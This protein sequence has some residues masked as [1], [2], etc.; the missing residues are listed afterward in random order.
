MI[1][2]PNKIFDITLPILILLCTALFTAELSGQDQ[3]KLS[4]QDPIEGPCGQS[5]KGKPRRIKGGEGFPPL[6]LPVTPL[7]R[8]ERKRNPAPPTLIGK[9]IWGQERELTRADGKTVRYFDWNNDPSDLKRLLERARK[10][11]GI[12]YGTK[13]LDPATFSFDPDEIPILWITGTQAVSFT[14]ELRANLRTYLQRGGSLWGDACRGSKRFSTAF[15]KEIALILP[16]GRLRPL[17]PDHPIFTSAINLEGKARYSPWTDDRPD[18]APYLEGINI[19]CRTAILFCPYA[20]TCAWDS[21]HIS[22]G[23]AQ[24]EEESA[25]AL[26]M[27]MLAYTLASRPLGRFLAQP[28]NAFAQDPEPGGFVFAQARF[29]GE[30]NPDPGAFGRLLRS[31]TTRTH[32]KVALNHPYL[33]L[34]RIHPRD[35]PFLYLTGHGSFSLSSDERKGLASF[36]AAGGFLLADACCGDLEFDR[37][38]RRLM[39]SL[40]PEGGLSEIP[41]NDPLFFSPATI[42]TVSYTPRVRVTWPELQRPMLEG[43]AIE[44]TWRVVYSRFD[45]G[46]GWE[47]EPHPYSLGLAP[48]DAT[49]IALNVIL[50]AITH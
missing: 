24:M 35:Y 49:R 18:G 46:C 12:R 6:P 5:P 37:S 31:L 43:I 40:F 29:N 42:T 21:G 47:G 44:G 2:A 15:R 10:I 16:Q 41:L 28:V 4:G 27:N 39:D 36:L 9:V 34:N 32:V 50:Y 23:C 1:N 7:R 14:P 38:F 33:P 45:L 48:E 11:L 3:A 30:Y 8:T 22:Q 25:M 17:A 13:S 19:G 26:G 20:L